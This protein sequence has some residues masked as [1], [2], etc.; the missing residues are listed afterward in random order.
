M[1]YVLLLIFLAYFMLVIFVFFT[2]NGEDIHHFYHTNE[3]TQ[4]EHKLRSKPTKRDKSGLHFPEIPLKSLKNIKKEEEEPSIRNTASTNN[5]HKDSHDHHDDPVFPPRERRRIVRRRDED[6]DE[7]DHDG[8]G[9]IKIPTTVIDNHITHTDSG[10]QTQSPKIVIQG[11][12]T[13]MQD[14]TTGI[15][16]E[17]AEIGTG[18]HINLRDQGSGNHIDTYEAGTSTDVETIDTGT[19]S[20]LVTQ[21][22]GVGDPIQVHDVGTGNPIDTSEMGTDAHTVLIDIGINTNLDTHD[23][24]TGNHVDLQDINVGNHVFLREIGIGDK[25]EVEEIGVGNHLER[26]EVGVG[27]HINLTEVAIGTSLNLHDIGMQ[28]HQ[29]LHE[30]G[31]GNSIS[32]ESESL[33]IPSVT[34][35]LSDISSPSHISSPPNTTILHSVQILEQDLEDMRDLMFNLS[36]AHSIAPS[37]GNSEEEVPVVFTRNDLHQSFEIFDEHGNYNLSR[38]D[39]V[40]SIP[41]DLV[42]E[43]EVMNPLL[44][45]NTTRSLLIPGENNN[46]LEGNGSFHL[47][48]VLTTRSVIF[49]NAPEEELNPLGDNGSFHLSRVRTVQSILLDNQSEKEIYLSRLPILQ[50]QSLPEIE[51]ISPMSSPASRSASQIIDDENDF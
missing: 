11:S 34:S 46:Y 2:E 45:V 43:G 1:P 51:S 8:N 31:V 38:L 49:D 10:T 19:G 50:S 36:E 42:P 22:I 32:I 41:L 40:N 5:D 9:G 16:I 39:I 7:D 25:L 20:N 24:G 13:E 47:S 6:E 15:D 21:E 37:A 29:E 17:H 18:N 27:N 26:K 30:I 44:S 4:D 28:T 35:I 48:R 23:V 14:A 33:I 3:V 12:S